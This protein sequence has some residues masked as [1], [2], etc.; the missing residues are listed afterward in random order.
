MG[1]SIIDVAKLLS[2]QI[3]S[4]ELSASVGASD[5]LSVQISDEEFEKIQNQVKGLMTMDSAINS[6]EVAKAIKPKLINDLGSE[7]R[8]EAK[9]SI[10]ETIEGKFTELGNDL[11]LDLSGKKLDEQLGMIK[12]AK[13]KEGSSKTAQDYEKLNQDF[14]KFKEQA[15]QEKENLIK[16][17]KNS[18][19]NA[20]LMAKMSSVPL[21]KAYQ[22]PVI[23]NS[24]MEGV[25]KQVR[26]KAHLDLDETGEIKLFNPDNKDME[27][28]VEN[29]K[30]GVDDLVNPLMQPYIQAT[31]SKD[32]DPSSK[33]TIEVNNGNGLPEGTNAGSAGALV[34]GQGEKY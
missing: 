27:L 11:G 31:P 25:L 16:E 5:P 21:A 19:I 33:K 8:G 24:L 14:L 32:R 4:N 2:G 17:H 20:K 6:P 28:F 1:K 9:K 30:I 22:D 3:N 7:L 13:T 23:K 10:Y 26:S 15:E 12:A 29:K 34:R 18:Q